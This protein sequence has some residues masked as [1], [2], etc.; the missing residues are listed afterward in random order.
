MSTLPILIDCDGVLADFTEGCLE[1]ARSRAGIFD[2]TEADI[3][4]WDTGGCLGWPGLDVAVDH[5]LRHSEFCYRLGEYEGAMH[6]FRDVE[7]EFGAERVF[8]CTS[9]W[10][11]DWA[12]QRAAWLEKRGIPLKQQ[13]QCSAKHLIPGYL[14]DDRP[15]V[16]LTR[17]LS[18]T[19]T[20]ARPWNADDANVR[21]DYAAATAWLRRVTATA[22]Q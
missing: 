7:L 22:S 4:R 5:A 1:L 3:T 2:K 14:I 11:A 19:F 18:Q 8:V 12:G 15:G 17:A 13:I 9:P 20:L 6:W 10:N 16:S 21:G